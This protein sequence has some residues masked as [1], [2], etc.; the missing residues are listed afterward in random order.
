MKE[1]QREGGKKRGMEGEKVRSR[2]VKE[3]GE[4]DIKKRMNSQV[5][6]NSLN[7]Q[8]SIWVFHDGLKH[9]NYQ[10]LPSQKESWKLDRTRS[11][12]N[13]NYLLKWNAGIPK[14]L[15]FTMLN[16]VEF[17]SLNNSIS[18]WNPYEQFLFN[19]YLLETYRSLWL[20]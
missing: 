15:A 3:S 6:S 10:P 17:D 14:T 13:W 19:Y 4:M 18:I 8:R 16:P 7:T 9:L 11:H 2:V 1:W 20:I 12:E 5:V